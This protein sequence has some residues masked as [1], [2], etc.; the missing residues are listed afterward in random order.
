MI[1]QYIYI[2]DI[3]GIT[4]ATLI[5]TFR[6]FPVFPFTNVMKDRNT[7]SLKSLVW[8][9]LKE[10]V[11]CVQLYSTFQMEHKTHMLDVDSRNIFWGGC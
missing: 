8:F 7:L 3:K 9:F 10:A 2:L 5:Y 4:D 6:Y 11:E 1:I